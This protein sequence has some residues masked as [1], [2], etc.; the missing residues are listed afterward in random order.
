MIP[1]TDNHFH[2]K[3]STDGR[4]PLEAV[5]KRMYD[6]GLKYIT[7]TE[8]FDADPK[9]DGFG[10]YDYARIAAVLDGLRK[11]FGINIYHGV[12][13][14]YQTEHEGEIK[15]FIKG[16]E[17]DL[18]IGSVHYINGVLI[19]EYC[20]NTDDFTDYFDLAEELSRRDYFDV[21]GHL[22]YLRKYTDRYEEKKHISRI[23]SI[24]ANIIGK[25]KSLEINTSG[26]RHS[27]G[28]QYPSDHIL[29]MYK[30]MGGELLSIGSDSH[31]VGHVCTGYGE[32][33]TK[34]KKLGFG[35]H[36]FYSRHMPFDLKI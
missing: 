32:V 11:E 2:S 36:F 29:S 26:Y 28:M 18:I 20:Q 7:N 31:A 9:D 19:S 21:F 3:F 34:L 10:F 1:L 33:F 25:G 4:S 16:N 27:S 6:S 35:K 23:E 8:H 14:T 13:T 15:D 30:D 22:D 17:F 12:E 24:L 5:V